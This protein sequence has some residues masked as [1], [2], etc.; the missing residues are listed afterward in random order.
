MEKFFPSP[1]DASARVADFGLAAGF[2]LIAINY[3]GGS[4]KGY[5]IKLI[6][7]DLSE[8][9]EVIGVPEDSPAEV[10]SAGHVAGWLASA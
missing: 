5:I 3:D 6:R 7:P 8:G 1:I 9:A 4:E 2:K 10:A